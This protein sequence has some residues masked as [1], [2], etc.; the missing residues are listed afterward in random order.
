MVW[1]RIAER[2]RKVLL[3]ARLLGAVGKIQRESG[4]THLVVRQLRD[5][6]SLLGGPVTLSRISIDRYNPGSGEMPAPE[7]G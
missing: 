2:Q 4:V 3:S 7:P 1:K 6:S 5:Y